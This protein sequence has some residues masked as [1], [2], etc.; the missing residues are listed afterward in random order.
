[1]SHYYKYIIPMVIIKL[2]I[3]FIISCNADDFDQKNDAM[4]FYVDTSLLSQSINFSK[5]E[6]TLRPPIDWTEVTGK[7]FIKAANTIDSIDN[8]YPIKLVNLFSSEQTSALMIFEI[9]GDYTNFDY[10]PPDF[11]A[12]LESQFSIDY[13]PF[14]NFNIG[15]VPVRQYVINAPEVIIFKLFTS[16]KTNYEIDYI[17]PRSEYEKELKKI[18]SSIGSIN[19]KQKGD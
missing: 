16:G 1:M 7:D 18:E 12:L 19:R 15:N 9:N 14:D 6:I 4:Q 13:V 3:F 2:S 11:S 17:I 5:S 8:L 10:L